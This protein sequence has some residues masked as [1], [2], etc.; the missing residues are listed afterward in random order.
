VSLP[1]PRFAEYGRGG[2]RAGA[3]RTRRAFRFSV[4]FFLVFAGALWFNEY[5]LRH[6]LHQAH[7]LNALTHEPESATVILKQAVT[8]ATQA[9]NP[10]A[11]NYLEALAERQ[12]PEE[13]VESYRE[14]YDKDPSTPSLPL[15]FG[16]ALYHNGQYLE[17]R[18]MFQEAAN[19]P[20]KN[21]LPMYLEAATLPR[22]T[23]A[24]VNLDESLALV[25]RT[26]NSGL[27][28][29]FPAPLWFKSLPQ[30][31]YWYANLR[32]QIAERCSAVLYQYAD[33]VV[34]SAQQDTA[35][36]QAQYWVPWLEQLQ[37]M[38][39][40]LMASADHGTVQ[41]TAGIQI[42]LQALRMRQEIKQ[43]VS[44]EADGEI[45]ERI[46][47]LEDALDILNGF[48]RERDARIAAH[49]AM[50]AR[51]GRW[52]SSAFILL[53]TV[54]LLSYA[55]TKKV[56]VGRASWSVEHTPL[57]KGVL[58]AWCVLT[59]LLLH[60]ATGL[61]QLA[62]ADARGMGLPAGAWWLTVTLTILF[63]FA[64][65]ALA[66]PRPAL[67]LAKHG[68]QHDA[69]ACHD[70]RHEYWD[71]YLSLQR[72]YFGIAVGFF[73]CSLATWVVTYRLITSLYPW[74]IKLLASGLGEREARVVEQVLAMLQ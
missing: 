11:V 59:F 10:A 19:Q 54:Y 25:A 61:Q 9:S 2:D 5:F 43:R 72:R 24:E 29:R 33:F 1:E 53:V 63:G 49:A 41:A 34:S 64:Y 35:L 71:T 58:A 15:R 70:A 40:R 8:E 60:S 46:R 3:R 28:V 30:G 16:V 74:Q 57:A 31:G 27:E 38:G 50:Y 36:R 26:N 14:A 39:Q 48:E 32:R 17:A 12:D 44:A 47:K 20:Q 37:I 56:R 73:L 23:G 13:A 4:L 65:P 22:L 45:V 42:Q 66:V 51:P 52:I 7:Y 69:A 18:R 6:E 62:G 67:V 55:A 68:L 21:A